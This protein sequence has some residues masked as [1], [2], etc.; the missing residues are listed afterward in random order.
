MGA[1]RAMNVHHYRGTLTMPD[2]EITGSGPLAIVGNGCQ[3]GGGLQVTPRARIDDGLLDVLAVR[4]IPALALLTTARE[5]Q[6]LSPDGDSPYCSAELSIIIDATV[7]GS[8]MKTS[9]NKKPVPKE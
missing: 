6:Q 9:R 5:L 4:D 2:R 1:I 8:T 7:K 3:A